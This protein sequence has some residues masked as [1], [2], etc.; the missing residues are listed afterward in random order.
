MATNDVQVEVIHA[1]IAAPHDLTLR[2]EC[3]TVQQKNEDGQNHGTQKIYLFYVS[4]TTLTDLNHFKS[5]L[6]GSF[7]EAKQ[8]VVTLY[9]DHPKALKLLLQMLHGKYDKETYEATL[10][11]VWHLFQ[12]ALKR[13]IPPNALV[14]IA[15]KS[16]FEG[17]YERHDAHGFKYDD[18]RMLLYPCYTF[19]YA[20]GFAAAT[21]FLAYNGHRHITEKRPDG[22]E[23]DKLRLHQGVIR[24]QS[25]VLPKLCAN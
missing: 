18:Y 5:M 20:S 22:I 17:W 19:D 4:R 21:K 3:E 11:T 10:E 7:S 13:E 23:N 25:G 12:V 16:W 1:T 8:D 24:K 2:L 15:G 6:A 9:D 14:D